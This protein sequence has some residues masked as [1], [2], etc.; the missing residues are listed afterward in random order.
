MRQIA[1]FVGEEVHPTAAEEVGS[2]AGEAAGGCNSE[3]VVRCSAVVVVVH[4]H[5][6]VGEGV[7]PID[8]V[9]VAHHRVAAADSLGGEVD[10]SPVV[11]EELPIAVVVDR[12]LVEVGADH[13]AALHLADST[14]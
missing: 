10:Y 2:L 12:S 6:L 5:N 7:V 3:V 13:R 8:C 14:T 9:E 11:E 1:G 4:R